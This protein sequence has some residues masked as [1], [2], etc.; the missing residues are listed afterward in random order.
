[1]L[2]SLD[3]IHRSLHGISVQLLVPGSFSLLPVQRDPIPWAQLDVTALKSNRYLGY[4]TITHPFHPLRGM[5][6]EILFCRTFNDRDIFSLKDT[7]EGIVPTIPRDWTDR[8]DPD[9]YQ[10]L[11]DYHF[12]TLSLLHLVHLADLIN[13]LKQTKSQKLGG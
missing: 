3:D 6:F 12:P 1:M 2:I 4:A 8:A 9:P 11:C 7:P 10:F 13:V 5:R